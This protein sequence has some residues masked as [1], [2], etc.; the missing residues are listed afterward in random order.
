MD[1]I[2]GTVKWVNLDKGFAFLS[3]PDILEIFCDFDEIQGSGPHTL[4][5]GQG[6]E[7]EVTYSPTQAVNVLPL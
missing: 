1:R 6:V 3:A 2:Q 5:V 4:T 7:F